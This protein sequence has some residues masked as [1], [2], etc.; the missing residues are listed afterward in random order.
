MFSAILV[1]PADQYDQGRSQSHARM[2]QENAGAG[3]GT[4]GFLAIPVATSFP[5]SSLY[6]EKVLWL[7]LVTCLCIQIRI[8]G[9]SLT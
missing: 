2:L 6:L 4:G 3:L 9:G 1:L 5:G 8:G 7:R